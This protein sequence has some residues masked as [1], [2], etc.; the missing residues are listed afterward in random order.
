M[1]TQWH[2]I[3]FVAVFLIGCSN[4]PDTDDLPGASAGGGVGPGTLVPPAGVPESIPEPGGEPEW[5]DAVDPLRA[6]TVCAAIV[7][8]PWGR[9]HGSAPEGEGLGPPRRT[10]P[11]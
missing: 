7:H 9:L 4:S 1:R 3:L 5:L 6:Q 2:W 8:G 10:D 11:Q